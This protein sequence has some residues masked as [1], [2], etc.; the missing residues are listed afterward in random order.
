MALQ[1]LASLDERIGTVQMTHSRFTH[2]A[3]DRWTRQ[4]THFEELEGKLKQLAS[5]DDLARAQGINVSVCLCFF[6]AA[7]SKRM[8]CLFVCLGVFFC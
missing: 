5:R 6:S 2:E 7:V 4:D 1:T 8:K 3:T